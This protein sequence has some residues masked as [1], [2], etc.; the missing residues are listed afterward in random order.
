MKRILVLSALLLVLTVQISW[1]SIPEKISYQGY[2]TDANG[3]A[4]PDST[5]NLT[6]KIYLLGAPTEIWSE[7]HSSVVVI[8]GIFN[9]ILGSVESLTS[10][11]FEEEYELGV[12]VN[13]G[14][15]MTPRKLLTAAAYSL[16]ARS[17]IDGAVTEDKI[18]AAA[19]TSNKIRDG[20]VTSNKIADFA[21]T[22]FKIADS[23]VTT[24]KIAANAIT[25]SKIA[26]NAVTRNK[27]LDGEVNTS[28]IADNAV[29]SGKIADGQVTADDLQNSAVSA[30]K[31]ADNAVTS[32][33]IANGA[34]NNSNIADNAVTGSKIANG[35]VVR[36]INGL[37]DDVT[38]AEGS[39]VTITPNGQQ[40]VISAAATGGNFKFGTVTFTET[41]TITIDEL[42]FRPKLVEI[43]AYSGNWFS[44]VGF[45]DG[46]NNNCVFNGFTNWPSRPWGPVRTDMS[47][48]TVNQFS[49]Q[50][51]Y[52][53][54]DNFGPDGFR[55]NNFRV[56]NPPGGANVSILWVAYQ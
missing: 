19:V 43:H 21:I 13:D 3:V 7:T 14:P 18:A 16:S 38:L 45:S 1:G 30:S 6:F 11:D 5:Y 56:P 29:T 17:I 48:W 50:I 42:G 12:T 27:I 15:E 31:I 28:D 35:H 39:N 9:V 41:D 52:G 49:D 44:S 4:V 53:F 2:L 46:T 8:N 33:K 20:N 54:C 47:W 36:N 51:A 34:V 22:M 23:A 37:A 24:L 40:L 55:L 25:N 26:D 10:L 32:S